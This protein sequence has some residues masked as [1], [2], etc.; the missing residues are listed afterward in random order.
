MG[1]ADGQ[2]KTSIDLISIF[3]VTPPL[4]GWPTRA[5]EAFLGNVVKN[6]A[7][8]VKMFKIQILFKVV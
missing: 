4:E 8:F 1:C 3:I 2:Y 7:K 5:K 6:D